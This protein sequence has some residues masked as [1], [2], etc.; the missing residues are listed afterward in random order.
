MAEAAYH[1]ALC[2][3]HVASAIALPELPPWAR[4]AGEPDVAIVLGAVPDRIADPTLETPY[5]QTN[6]AGQARYT[7]AGV[8]S[9]FLEAGRRITVDAAMPPDAPDVR[10]FLLASVFGMLCNQRGVLP[11]H[12]CSVVV[13][14]GAIAFAGASGMGKSTLAA[15]FHR[16]GFPLLADD[17][18]PVD[19]SG[20]T[21]RFLPGLR[22]IR[23]WGDSMRAAGWDPAGLERCRSGLDKFSRAFDGGFASAPAAPLAIFHLRRHADPDS[24]ARFNR[25]Q[26]ATALQ[27][28]RRQVYRGRMLRG[29]VGKAEEMLRVARAAAG[30]PRHYEIARRMDF[31]ELDA[32]IDAVLETVRQGG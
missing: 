13:E 17:V 12:A 7:L 22:R 30:I 6:Q 5:L 2:G 8:A 20:G 18:T 25:I 28:L 29:S 32:V 16:R 3:W 21:V 27:Q 11:L 9:Y 14:G 1:Y 26:G 10:L 4:V 15:A 23:L 31:A 19:L 24:G